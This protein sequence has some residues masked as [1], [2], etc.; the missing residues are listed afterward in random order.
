MSSGSRTTTTY[1]A[2]R[3]TTTPSSGVCVSTT[4]RPGCASSRAN[5]SSSAIVSQSTHGDSSPS[6][7]GSVAVP[8]TS[9]RQICCIQ[10]VP[11]LDRVLTT[12]SPARNGKRLQRSLS[13]SSE[14]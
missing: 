9:I 13:S 14:T 6:G 10:V 12:T 8:C 4:R 11:L 7:A 2:R 1:V 3:S 5:R